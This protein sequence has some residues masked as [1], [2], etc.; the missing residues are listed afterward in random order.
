MS[1][2]DL[3]VRITPSG[4]ESELPAPGMM[5]LMIMIMIQKGKTMMIMIIV[6]VPGL[7]L[8]GSTLV[9]CPTQHNIAG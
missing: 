5:I 3:S 8:A 4:T 2:S 6:V 7:T 9:D 1:K